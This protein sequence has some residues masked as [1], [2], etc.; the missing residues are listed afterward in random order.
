LI[1]TGPLVAYFNR[2]D[3]HHVRCAAVFDSLAPPLYTCWPVLT[4]AAYL[5]LTQGGVH[6]VQKLLDSCGTGFLEIL[7]LGAYDAH[8]IADFLEK[9]SD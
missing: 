8:A 4:E 3:Q 1:D 2:R 5:L 6:L 7:P 9:F